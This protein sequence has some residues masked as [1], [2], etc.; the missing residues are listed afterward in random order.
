MPAIQT[1]SRDGRQV[2]QPQPHEAAHLGLV[3]AEQVPAEIEAERGLLLLQPLALAPGRRGD[4]LGGGRRGDLVAAEQA[5][6]VGVGLALLGG[7]H[8]ARHVGQQLGAVGSSASNAPALISA[9]IARRLT[10]RLSTRAQKSYRQAKGP[11]S[12]RAAGCS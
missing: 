11:P 8:R 2:G 4:P 5:H 10:A 3:R 1:G 6:L 7:F 9:S 12:A